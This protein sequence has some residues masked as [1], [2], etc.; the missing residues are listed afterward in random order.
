M[1]V[2]LALAMIASLTAV[3]L[4]A[5]ESTRA[6]ASVRVSDEGVLDEVVVTARHREEN[7]QSAPT[8]VSVV[9]GDLL[10]STATVKTQ[11]LS[12]LVP[13]LYFNSANPATRLTPFAGWAPTRCP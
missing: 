5:Q 2:N 3:S 9:T 7:L 1:R 6:V 4:A 13:S 8:A 11:Q 12:Q 10:D